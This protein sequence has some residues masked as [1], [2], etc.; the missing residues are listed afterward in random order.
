M[1]SIF[2]QR[3]L[4]ELR[5]NVGKGILPFGHSILLK[6]RLPAPVHLKDFRNYFSYSLDKLR[7]SLEQEC[8][9]IIYF[10]L[11]QP[12]IYAISLKLLSIATAGL[13]KRKSPVVCTF[14]TVQ[15]SPKCLMCISAEIFSL[16]TRNLFC[17]IKNL[18]NVHT[19]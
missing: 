2:K 17:L 15:H 12:V 13:R 6:T 7:K 9:R 3:G 19:R 1:F 18:Q 8:G 14:T 5:S 11:T 4:K 16:V 10:T